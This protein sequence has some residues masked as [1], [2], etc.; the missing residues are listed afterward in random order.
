[1]KNEIFDWDWDKW[2]EEIIL[3]E[4][5]MCM[6]A[7]RQVGKSEVFGYK[8][9]RLMLKYPGI[10]FIIIAGAERQAT[11]IYDK[12]VAYLLGDKE[13]EFKSTPTKEKCIL[14]NGSSMVTYPVGKTGLY[15]KGL[16]GDV[17]VQD[18]AELIPDIVQ[19]SVSPMLAVSE[20]T[21]GFGWSWKLGVPFGEGGHFWESCMDPDFKVW[22]INAEDCSRWTKKKLDKEKKRMTKQEYQEEVQGLFIADRKQ[23][24]PTKLIKKQMTFIEWNLKKDKI[25]GSRLYCGID[26]A[27]WGGDENAW[28]FIEMAPGP[29][30]KLKIFKRYMTERTPAPETLKTTV[31]FD[32][33][34]KFKKIFVDDGGLG[35]STTDFMKE[36]FGRR[37]MG[38]NNSKRRFQEQGEDLK[39]GI[40]KEDL[41]SNMLMLMETGKLEI[42]ADSEIARSLKSVTW[43]SSKEKGSKHVKIYGKY[44]HIAEAMVR[45]CWCVKERGLSLFAY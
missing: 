8:I 1:M 13:I 41:Y 27:G 11:M 19:N 33:E 18:E 34:F 4:G 38:L 26:L 29:K 14:K 35:S 23:L 43:E 12:A 25:D 31:T 37:V 21:R 9:K 30:V 28:A 15:I 39:K 20:S 24:F 17:V 22:H 44:T 6:H 7:G 32:N 36:K 2:Q 16:T 45:A 10:R 42:L 3:H 40:L 5:D